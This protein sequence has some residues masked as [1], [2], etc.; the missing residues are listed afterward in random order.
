MSKIKVLVYGGNGALGKAC[1]KFFKNKNLP[2]GSIDSENNTEADINFLLNFSDPWVAQ[3]ECIHEAVSSKLGNDKLESIICVTGGFAGGNTDSEDFKKN[4]HMMWQKCVWS[5]CIAASL[6]TKFLKEGGLLTLTGA[7]A[8]LKGTPEMIGYGMAKAAVHHFTKSLAGQNS[9][10]PNN[11]Q[12]VA[13]LPQV[14]DTPRNRKERPNADMSTWTPLEF[15][16]ELLYKWITVPGERPP[17]GSLASLITKDK[18]S[19]YVI[20]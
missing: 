15:V 18:K 13:I 7:N 19:N 12:V 1:V 6:C 3:K 2:V 5:S 9:G 14:L 17:N 4:C 16:A 10:L 8:A 20:V 11:T